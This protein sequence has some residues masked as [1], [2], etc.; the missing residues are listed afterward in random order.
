M[1]ELV[2][3]SVDCEFRIP[4]DG[5]D[6]SRWAGIRVRGF[7]DNIMFGYL[8]YMRSSGTVELYRAGDVLAGMNEVLVK[9]TKEQWTKLRFDIFD[10]NIRIWVNDHL[11]INRI[12]TRFRDKG[13]VYLHS[14]GTHVQI[15]DFAVY[16]F[17]L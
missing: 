6:P 5:G 2:D 17:I 1:E 4:D 14:F 8:A 10:T 11:H 3:V 15:R 16:R 7:Q 9:D 12:D 13:L